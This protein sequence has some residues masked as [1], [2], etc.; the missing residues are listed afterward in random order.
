[1][2]ALT[3]PFLNLS[4]TDI[5]KN[6]NAEV[7]TQRDITSYQNRDKSVTQLSPPQPS[8]FSKQSTPIRLAKCFEDEETQKNRSDF[9]VSYLLCL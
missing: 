9:F 1:M 3:A 6:K 7:V 4:K 8:N 5:G 2:P